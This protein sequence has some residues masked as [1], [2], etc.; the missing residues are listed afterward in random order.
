MI[1]LQ[2]S[3]A[4]L[5]NFVKKM[6]T[7]SRP[8]PGNGQGGC[9]QQ[10]RAVVYRLPEES[11]I[12][13]THL[14]ISKLSKMVGCLVDALLALS[15]DTR[16]SPE[17]SPKEERGK[18]PVLDSDALAQARL[19]TEDECRVLFYTL[20]I[21]GIPKMHARAIALLIKYAGSQS[22]WGGFIIKVA[23]DLFGGQ[24][25]AVFNKER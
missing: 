21:D 7:D 18:F 22:W 19:L 2:V 15:V 20:C 6:T 11:C 14:S 3:L 8:L 24:Q 25:T 17:V 9:G 5:R 23:A 1:C 10:G 13:C 4:R 16:P 12:D